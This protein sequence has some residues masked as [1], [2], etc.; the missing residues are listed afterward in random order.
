MRTDYGIAIP[1][2]FPTDWIDTSGLRDYLRTAERLGYTSCWVVEQAANARFDLAPL[3]LLS[4]AAA[5][6]ERMTLG[7]G[8]L[9]ALARNP[10]N[11]AKSLATIDRLSNGRLIVGFGMGSRH[12]NPYLPAFGVNPDRKAD[13]LEEGIRLLR[14]LWSGEP[15]TF[16]GDFW[17]IRDVFISPT[18]VQKPVPIWFGGHAKVALER[19]ARMGNG[20][21]GASSSSSLAFKGHVAT[22]RA[23]LDAHGRDPSS[24]KIAKRVFVAVERDREAALERMLPWF[25]THGGDLERIKSLAVYGTP[26]DCID[27]LRQLTELEIDMLVLNPVHDMAVQ[28][29]RLATEVLPFV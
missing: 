20:W 12:S 19:A 18:P 7:S 5:V 29:E 14:L 24:F 27:G 28:A 6:T 17:N 8:V 4:Y 3:P 1:Q 26:D 25:T 21:I 22:L 9:V 11:L 2:R 10:I 16:D 23:L 13:R 15:V